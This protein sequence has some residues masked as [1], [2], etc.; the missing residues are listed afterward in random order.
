[1][2]LLSLV[3]VLFA[4]L[5]VFSQE[6]R[7]IRFTAFRTTN[8]VRISG[9][10]HNDPLLGTATSIQNEEALHVAHLKGSVELMV[11]GMKLQA[12]ELD[13]HWD[14]GDIEPRGNVHLTPIQ[15]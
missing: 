12:D 2:R 9:T 10:L 6:Q 8:G 11:N 1:M 14:S 3:I 7:A 13:L 4:C 15:Q 5:P